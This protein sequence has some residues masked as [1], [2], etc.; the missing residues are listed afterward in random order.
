MTPGVM[1][2]P[3]N[4]LRLGHV[5]K[6]T[7]CGGGAEKRRYPNRETALMFPIDNRLGSEAQQLGRGP[8]GRRR[9]T[10]V[11]RQAADVRVDVF[12][13]AGRRVRS[14]EP[15]ARLAAGA[16]D[17]RWEPGKAAIGVHFV[18]ARVDLEDLP[19]RIVTIP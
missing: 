3:P 19:A 17:F 18:R 16:H 12:S 15:G 13:L 5:S 11:H 2:R 8:V 4:A 1:P 10:V 14:L 6:R 7:M 9:R